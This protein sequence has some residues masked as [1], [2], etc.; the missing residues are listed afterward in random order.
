LC[1]A[2]RLGGL[3]EPEMNIQSRPN[4]FLG[5]LRALRPTQMTVGRREVALK[6]RE[7]SSLK[8]KRRKQ[9]LEQHCFP[10]VLGPADCHYIVD[11]HH[12]GLALHEEGVKSVWVIELADFSWLNS[13][14]FWSNM[15]YRQ[16]VHPYDGNGARQSFDALPTRLQDMEDDP[17]RSLAGQV[18]R[19]GGFAKDSAPYSEFLW[20]DYFREKVAG[21]LLT[22]DFR[23]A[24]KIALELA[25]G[26][27]A[28][29]LPGWAGVIK[30]G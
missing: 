16:W 1:P 29:Y 21:K 12:F 22:K 17:Y 13:S 25:H 19:A 7:W 15:E 24:A 4:L 27:D 2:Y 5:K 9:L 18:Q 28:R 8:G 14:L 10:V 6:R 11:H 26:Q 23:H 30:V 3:K 20:A